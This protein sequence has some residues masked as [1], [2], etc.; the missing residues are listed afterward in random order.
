VAGLDTRKR[1]IT[2]VLAG[3]RTTFLGGSA[4]RAV[5]IPTELSRLLLSHN[6]MLPVVVLTSSEAGNACPQRRR[7][8][9]HRASSGA[10]LTGGCRSAPSVSP[11]IAQQVRQ[12]ALA[13][14]VGTTA[15]D[16]VSSAQSGSMTDT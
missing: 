4:H 15:G 14:I 3:S 9:T 11:I 16:A 2:L 5:A 7:R 13:H 8:S 6:R 12:R 1:D 10:R